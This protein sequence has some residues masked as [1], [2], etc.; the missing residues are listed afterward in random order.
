[1]QAQN[2]EH[3]KYPTGKFQFGKQYTYAE[4]LQS[5]ERLKSFPQSLQ[6][7]FNDFKKE[8]LNMI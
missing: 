8:N 3:L 2:I 6:D 4:T 7:L 5:I 1:M